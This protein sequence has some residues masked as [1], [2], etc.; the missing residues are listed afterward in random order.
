VLAIKP[1]DAKKAAE[2]MEIPKGK[3][4][5]YTLNDSLADALALC[6]LLRA[7]PAK[8]NV[9][10]FN[11]HEQSEF[12]RPNDDAVKRFQQVLFD[13]HIQVN[14]RRPRGD[15]IAAACGQLQGQAAGLWNEA[16]REAALQ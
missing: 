5:N 11:P 1:I 12:Q 7:V 15:D 4:G 9:I 6:R 10:P 13:H 3:E 8:V 14:V 16:G 2:A